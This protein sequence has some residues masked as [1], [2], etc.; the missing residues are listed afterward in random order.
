M[1]TWPASLP[2]KPLYKSANA[3]PRPNVISFGTEVGPGKQRRRSTART[4]ALQCAFAL[5][6]VQRAAFQSFFENDL[7]DGALSFT[8]GDPVTGVWASWRF[9]PG[10]PYQLEQ[11]GATGWKLTVNLIRQP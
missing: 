9:E 4:S 11:L 3:Q 5:T 8:W 6:D 1:P 7:S 2:Q 10:V